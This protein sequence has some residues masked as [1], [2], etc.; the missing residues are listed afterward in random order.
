MR[1]LE[2][3]LTAAFVIALFGL[4]EAS[5]ALGV[6]NARI[7][8]APSTIAPMLVELLGRGTV[9]KSLGVT[10]QEVVVAFLISVPVGFFIGFTLAEATGV[11]AVF[12]PLVT[13][14]FG[15]PKSIFLPVVILIFGVGFS[16][17]IVFGVFANFFALSLGGILHV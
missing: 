2:P 6:L 10:A 13:F 7:A 14:L 9:L 12:R 3:L 8:P 4:W 5:V 15:V 16:Q 17:K 11:S 1:W